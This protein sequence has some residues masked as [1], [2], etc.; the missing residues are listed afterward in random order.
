MEPEL[1]GVPLVM[2]ETGNSRSVVVATSE[3]AEQAGI[4]IG[5]KASQARALCDGLVVR[6][7]R[8]EVLAAAASALGDVAQTVSS[9]TERE[10][11]DCVFVDCR[12]SAVLWPSESALATTMIARARRCGLEAWVGIADSKLG[13]SI[14]AR[15]GGGVCIVP[16]GDVRRFLAPRAIALLGPDPATAHAL[17]TWGIRSIGDLL[18]LPTA[19][20]VHRLGAAGVGLIRRARGKDDAPV[21][22]R[23]LPCVF[24]ESLEVEYPVDRIEPLLFVLRRLFECL[25]ARLEL[26]GLGCQEVRVVL[27]SDR[28][29]RDVRSIPLATPT[30][31]RRTLLIL[32]RA[33]LESHPPSFAIATVAVAC[34][35]SH[36]R[37]TQLELFRAA[38]PTPAALAAVVA[39]LSILCGQDRVGVL[40]DAGTHR[41][42]A[43]RIEPFPGATSSAAG[44][45]SFSS[46]AAARVESS[47]ASPMVAVVRLALRAFR[48]PVSVEV[49]KGRDSLEHVRGAGRLG[50]RVLHW[51]GPWR[52]RGEWWTDDPYAREYYDVELSDGGVYRLYRDVR[53]STWVVD[54]V[55]D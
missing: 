12:G 49:F 29:G 27:G 41:L 23:S 9:Q 50:G 51:A 47:S 6:E 22:A 3:S 1:V 20:V 30:T 10:G 28:G 8:R 44:V 16:V 38:D 52:V 19:A 45:R 11:I 4:L 55:Y 13:A 18:A 17:A 31:D 43:L 14:A 53:S 48:P 26:Y 5:M 35:A 25:L 21:T 40:R 32:V 36:L 37:P 42:E 24:E 46:P 39:R 2:V 7:A 54:G 34:V 33:Q 15:E